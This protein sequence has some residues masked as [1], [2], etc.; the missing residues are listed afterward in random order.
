MAVLTTTSL[1]VVLA[2][3]RSMAQRRQTTA[4]F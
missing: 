1:M 2:M 4:L 3:M